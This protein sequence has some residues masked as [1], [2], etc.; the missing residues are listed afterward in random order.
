MSLLQPLSR[1]GTIALAATLW[2]IPSLG[3]A[4][5]IGGFGPFGGG[6]GLRGNSQIMMSATPILNSFNGQAAFMGVQDFQWFPV[7]VQAVQNGGQVAFVPQW[8][9][10]PRGMAWPQQ[11]VFFNPG[12]G[13]GGFAG[14]FDAGPTVEDL[15]NGLAAA[16]NA[17]GN[18]ARAN[19]A[20]VMNIAGVAPPFPINTFITPVYAGGAQGRATP[21][22]QIIYP[23]SMSTVGLQTTVSF[24][25]GGN[26]LLGRNF[27]GGFGRNQF[28]P[29]IR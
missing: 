16:Q 23:P 24:P 27:G 22:T 14:G 25:V 29:G 17:G 28:G 18:F 4:Q 13:G 20:P 2:L 8:Q 6:F 3:Y 10:I 26:A 19:V 5:G 11:V 12:G 15:L 7:N 21:F 9:P 1:C